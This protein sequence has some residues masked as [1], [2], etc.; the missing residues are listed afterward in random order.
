[1]PGAGRAVREIATRIVYWGPRGSGKTETLR[2][3]SARLDPETCG[4]LLAPAAEDGRTLLMDFLS[5]EMGALDGIPIRLHL[6]GLPGGD[7]LGEDTLALLRGADG[8]VF[9]ADSAPDRRA[10]N[11]S[12]LESLRRHLVAIG[13]PDRPVVLQLNRRDVPGAVGTDRLVSELA[14]TGDDDQWFE[15]VATEGR[16]V[17]EALTSV[18]SRVVGRLSSA[19]EERPGA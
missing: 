17:L 14:P 3:I 4:P 10:A 13:E 7:R 5:V 1:M 11:R 16:G 6:V 18:A 12:A 15:T 8:F 19:A 9:V 2:A